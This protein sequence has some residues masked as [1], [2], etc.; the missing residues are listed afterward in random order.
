[1]FGYNLFLCLFLVKPELSEAFM[2]S[3]N[4]NVL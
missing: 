3:L 1:M 4:K 2:C